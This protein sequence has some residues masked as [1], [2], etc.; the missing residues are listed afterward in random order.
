MNRAKCLLGKLCV[1]L[2]AELCHPIYKYFF[3]LLFRNFLFYWFIEKHKTY[4]IKDQQ[5]S[6]DGF[7]K[8]LKTETCPYERCR[9]SRICNHIHCVR[10]NCYYVL[11]SS[12]QLL[13]HKRKHERM[14]SEQAYRRFKMAQK[15]HNV[16]G[17]TATA[18][19]GTVTPNQLQEAAAVLTA[20]TINSIEL[21]NV[22]SPSISILPFKN[23]INSPNVIDD[24]MDSKLATGTKFPSS[25]T[26][27]PPLPL[28]PATISNLSLFYDAEIMKQL[29]KQ[30]KPISTDLPAKKDDRDD[31]TDSPTS[32]QKLPSS[33]VPLIDEVE[34]LIQSY[35][36]A[37]SIR[38]TATAANSEQNE[39][40]NLKN[41]QS[42]ADDSHQQQPL[43]HLPKFADC[44]FSDP[45]L[46]CLI[47]DCETIVPQRMFD[48][49]EHIRMHAFNRGAGDDGGHQQQGAGLT[50][51]TSVEGFFNRKRG[52]PPKNRVIEVYNNVSTEIIFFS[53]LV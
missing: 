39:P 32:V 12:G 25:T 40:L 48:I 6:R 18:P 42:D 7:K 28:P 52:R 43:Q 9:F 1:T 45:H 2:N 23:S 24:P 13:S 3:F 38:T 21:R 4:H 8:F 47:K 16:L 53:V 34:Q 35:F 11:H 29:Q 37:C 46:H 50:Q 15:V 33:S 5:L 51:I 10:E 31:D 27:S 14:D 41:Y 44:Q 30:Q 17:G 26:S 19:S 20:K 49:T 22:P 36:T